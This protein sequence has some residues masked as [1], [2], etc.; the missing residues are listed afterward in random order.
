MEENEGEEDERKKENGKH[1]EWGSGREREAC[2]RGWEG[3]WLNSHTAGTLGADLILRAAK[4]NTQGKKRRSFQRQLTKVSKSTGNL[5]FSQTLLIWTRVALP[6][7]TETLTS[8]SYPS[9]RFRPSALHTAGSQ[10]HAK[11]PFPDGWGA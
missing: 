1:L 11:P 7:R 4:V 5:P 6:A 3:A 8:S 2:R 9:P 10:T